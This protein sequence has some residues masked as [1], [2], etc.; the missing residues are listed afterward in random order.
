M[1]SQIDEQLRKFK[2]D[3]PKTNFEPVD[4]INDVIEAIRADATN[5]SIAQIGNAESIGAKIGE[6]GHLLDQ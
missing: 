1:N 4:Y 2:I 3:S 6:L 5:T